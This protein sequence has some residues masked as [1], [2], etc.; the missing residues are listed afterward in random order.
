M[1]LTGK[2]DFKGI[3]KWGAF[4][5]MKALYTIPQVGLLMNRIPFLNKVSSFFLELAV[6]W[7]ANNGLVVINVAI[8]TVDGKLDQKAFDSAMDEG[9][10]KMKIPG[11]SDA[12]KKAIDDAVIKAFTEF[13]R[14]GNSD[15]VSVPSNI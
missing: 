2:Y 6:N 3:K 5:I 12:Q 10:K 11:L 9:I 15:G 4:G 1:G 8:I 14:I 7:L 13:G